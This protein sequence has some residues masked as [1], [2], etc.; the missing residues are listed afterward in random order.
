LAATIVFLHALM[1]I[2]EYYL[3]IRVKADDALQEGKLTLIRLNLPRDT[4]S[5]WARALESPV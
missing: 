3:F 4:E 1:V 5:F 2:V